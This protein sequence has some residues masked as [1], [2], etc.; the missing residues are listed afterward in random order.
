[1]EDYEVTFVIDAQSDTPEH[2]A[3]DALHI[4]ADGALPMAKVQRMSD[5]AV[6]DIEM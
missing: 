6:F 3:E 5:G 4:I 2:A 1:M